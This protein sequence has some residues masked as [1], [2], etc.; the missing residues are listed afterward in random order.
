VHLETFMD[1]LS[2]WGCSWMWED[3]RLTGDDGWLAIAIQENT[4]VA[5]T[6]GSY[7][8][9]LCPINNSCAFILECTQGHGR[10]M[11]A[12]LE[13]TTS[14]CSY[15]RGLLGLMAIHLILLSVNRIDLM[16]TGSVH[17]YLD[18]LGAL[19]KIQNLLPHRIP[20]KCQHSDVLKNVMLHCSSLSF[21]SLTAKSVLVG[22]K[23]VLFGK[24]VLNFYVGIVLYILRETKTW[25]A[26]IYLPTQHTNWQILTSAKKIQF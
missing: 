10:L 23:L 17:I 6:D 13:Q 21:N 2:K 7:M 15:Q 24:Y 8:H 25:R 26:K 16:L 22:E 4:L 12:F 1:V 18:C 20:S 3:M 14:A 11:G 19:D 5:V 9:M